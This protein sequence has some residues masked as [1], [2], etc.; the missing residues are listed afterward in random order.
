MTIEASSG[1][2]SR[3]RASW[4]SDRLSGSRAIRIVFTSIASIFKALLQI[5]GDY[6]PTTT[7]AQLLDLVGSHGIRST[8]SRM[9]DWALEASSGTPLVPLK[10]RCAS[11]NSRARWLPGR[12]HQE[13]SP[14]CGKRHGAIYYPQDEALGGPGIETISPKLHS[15]TCDCLERWEEDPM[16]RRSNSMPNTRAFRE[17]EGTGN[18]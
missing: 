6:I 14:G 15:L 18:A 5:V 12:T 4:L 9:T 17:A 8:I 16:D 2:T 7:L 1:A 11:S 10:A 13:P 3:M